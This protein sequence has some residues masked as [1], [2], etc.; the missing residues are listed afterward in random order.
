MEEDQEGEAAREAEKDGDEAHL[1]YTLLH[2]L[3]GRPARYLNVEV[4]LEVQVVLDA[5]VLLIEE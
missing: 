3:C 1:R 4:L 5:E 2:L